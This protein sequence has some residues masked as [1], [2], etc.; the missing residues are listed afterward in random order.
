MLELLWNPDA[1]PTSST[2]GR[3]ADVLLEK[4][5]NCLNILVCY[6]VCLVQGY[7][8]FVFFFFNSTFLT[9]NET[10]WTYFKV[11]K[12]RINHNSPITPP[13]FLLKIIHEKSSMVWGG[14]GWW[15]GVCFG[16]LNI[17]DVV[18]WILAE[19]LQMLK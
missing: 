12:Y 13:T 8:T 16:D 1:T 14:E 9:C 15:R 19:A 3:V 5:Q 17:F 18:G 10:W 11:R 6:K 4:L 2:T 7:R